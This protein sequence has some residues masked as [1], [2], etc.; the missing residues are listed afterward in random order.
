[1]NDT[2][3][4]PYRGPVTARQLEALRHAAN[5]NTSAEIAHAMGI[6]ENTVNT[7]LRLAY[8]KL[9]AHDRAHAVA[10]CLVRGLIAAHDIQLPEPT[11]PAPKERR[12]A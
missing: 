2:T 1:M 9:G 11:T 5:G 4:A 7:M 6:S 3:P 12:V 8:R 10:L